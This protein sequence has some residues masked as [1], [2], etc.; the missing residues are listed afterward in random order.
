MKDFHWDDKKLVFIQS[1]TKTP[2]PTSADGIVSS[3]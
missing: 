1:K 3:L 2:I